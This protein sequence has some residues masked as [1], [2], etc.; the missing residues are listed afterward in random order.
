MYYYMPPYIIGKQF[1]EGCYSKN[2]V[3]NFISYIIKLEKL[4]NIQYIFEMYN[5]IN[6][7][8]HNYM[9][10]QCHNF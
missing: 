7:Y 2:H 5:C 6:N 3:H 8:L 4:Q 1:S 9:M 10:S